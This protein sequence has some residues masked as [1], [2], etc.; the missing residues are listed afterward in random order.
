VE[1]CGVM[2]RLVGYRVDDDV[3]TICDDECCSRK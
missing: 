2:L 3:G 1:V